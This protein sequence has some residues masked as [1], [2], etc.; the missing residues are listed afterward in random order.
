MNLLEPHSRVE[1]VLFEALSSL[2]HPG[3]RYKCSPENCPVPVTKWL[4][5]QI[6]LRG[7]YCKG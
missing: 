2:Q 6:G 5:V 3:I 1:G 4:K 7:P